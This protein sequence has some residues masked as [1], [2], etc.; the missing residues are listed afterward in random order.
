MKPKQIKVKQ[1]TKK[2]KEWRNKGLGASDAPIV[3]GV[4]PWTSP[5]E[6][7]GYKTGLIERPEPNVYQAIAMKRG[8][9][10]EPEARYRFEV[11]VGS[12]YPPTNF[13][14]SKYPFL[15]ASLDGY[16]VER[17]ENL[18]IKC[19]GKIDHAKAMKGVI[20]SKYLPQIQMQMLV[21]GAALT[22]YYSWD[23][24]LTGDSAA[25]IRI[26]EDK[27][28][29]EHL[30]K[31]MLHFWELIQLKIPPETNIKD[32]KNLVSQ[33]EKDILR[34]SQSIK[35]LSYLVSKQSIPVLDEDGFVK[36]T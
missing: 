20:P 30:L 13:E 33:L 29:Q 28:Y 6:L 23:G 19:P 18:E 34:T 15:R 7:W 17:N 24:S 26:K 25:I 4:S 16:N 9:N 10:L 22:N 32:T 8:H 1:N 5:F 3:M 35:V 21:S 2:W 27:V 14:H 11:C 36:V 31:K 12:C